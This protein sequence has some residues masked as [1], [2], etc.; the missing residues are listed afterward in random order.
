M[1]ELP[2]QPVGTWIGI[3]R[4]FPTYS[5][6]ISVLPWRMPLALVTADDIVRQTRFPIAAASKPYE[7]E[8]IKLLKLALESLAPQDRTLNS[9]RVLLKVMLADAE[10]WPFGKKDA[11]QQYIFVTAKA[12]AAWGTNLIRLML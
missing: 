7:T 2:R 1:A 8:P 11:L 6:R 9:V 5:R 4:S 3:L 12:L 10:F